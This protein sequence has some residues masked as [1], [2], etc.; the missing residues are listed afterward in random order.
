[1]KRLGNLWDKVTSFSNLYLAYK[2]AAKGKRNQVKVAQF[3]Y[4]LEAELFAMQ[5]ELRSGSY[6][7]GGYRKF[8]IFDRKPREISAAPFRDRVLHHAIM[9][10]LEPI[11]E[12]RFYHH[13]YACRKGKGAHLA[14]NVYQVW[15]RKYRYV[16]KLD[17]RS[18]FASIN[19]K[20]LFDKIKRVIKDK[21]LLFLI[22]ELLKSPQQLVGLPMGNL[23]SQCFANLFLNELDHK[24]ASQ[25]PAYLRYVD[26]LTIMS[27]CK[28]QLW[29]IQ[30]VIESELVAIGLVLHP[31]K[32]SL[33]R[34]VQKVDML[35]YKVSSTR[36]WVRNDN[37]Y[38]FARKYRQKHRRYI[39]G[40][41][42]LD[43]VKASMMAWIGHAVHG[44]SVG[45]RRAIISPLNWAVS[46]Q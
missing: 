36:R 31:R 29:A 32:Q 7:F 5:A 18:F 30:N 34:T 12:A 4:Q 19:N 44:E 38:R 37:G 3:S 28:S 25:S 23:T 24:V 13:S 20:I 22:R 41:L 8:I 35:G 21:P 11:F 45:L 1:M 42:P 40:K 17:I 6:R 39:Q 43:F 27:N 16:L 14:V 10:V 9:N 46:A 33:L 26:D 15:A 2:K